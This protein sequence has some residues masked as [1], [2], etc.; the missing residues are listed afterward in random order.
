MGPPDSQA[1]H[2][3]SWAY[4]PEHQHLLA[5]AHEDS[6]QGRVRR[7]TEDDLAQLGE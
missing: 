4:T 7:L 2:D 3:D 6:R 1:H 5:R